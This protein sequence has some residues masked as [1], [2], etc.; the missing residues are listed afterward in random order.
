M[1]MYYLKARIDEIKALEIK[2][3]Y[4]VE[5]RS[6]S[7]KYQ[8]FF[9]KGKSFEINCYY[10]KNLFTITFSS[11]YKDI[12]IDEAEKFLLDFV[13]SNTNDNKTKYIDENNQ[14]GSDEVGVG[15]FF[16]PLIVVS[17]YIE[18]KDMD[19]LTS[20]KIQDSKKMK[21]N[22]IQDIGL[23]LVRR[24]KNY[25]VQVSPSKL[26][27][28]ESIGMNKNNILS[29]IHNL[30]HAGIIKKYNLPSSTIIYVDQF[31]PQSN[32][33]KY[34]ESE[35]VPNQIYFHTSGESYFPSVAVSSVIARYYLLK[36]F[37]KLKELF[38]I[39]IPKGAS[40]I[41]DKTYLKLI[42]KNKKEKVD[43]QVKQ[44]FSNYSRLNS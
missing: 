26:S 20:L 14:I 3:Y 18:S 42:K 22:Y 25:V 41:V 44:Y 27:Y 16:G 13:I 28:L 35:I 43:E 32:Y 31:V 10:S 36:A 11:E 29:K 38:G 1:Y 5:D 15:D 2:D 9:Y 7:N 24:I 6:Y 39:E 12:I 40:D 17:S 34:V 33:K 19:Y 23:K 30:S 21:D 4:H 8:F 37:D